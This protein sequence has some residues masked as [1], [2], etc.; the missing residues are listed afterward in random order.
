MVSHIILTKMII[1]PVIQQVALSA[2]TN[3]LNRVDN[4][5]NP[6][7]MLANHLIT[8]QPSI[9]HRQIHIQSH[10]LLHITLNNAIDVRSPTI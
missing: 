2:R 4:F 9:I 6:R 1:I 5:R 7:Q 10:Q 8:N 3:I